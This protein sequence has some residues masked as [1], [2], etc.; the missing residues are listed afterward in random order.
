MKNMR[1]VARSAAVIAGVVIAVTGVTYAALQSPPNKLTGNTIQTATA[2]LLVSTDGTNYAMSHPGF[3]FTGL[4]PGGSAVP[5]SGYTVWVRS[6]GSAT[7]GLKLSVP[8]TPS[9][10]DGVDLSKVSIVLTPI[11][12]GTPQTFSLQSLMSSGGVDV[13]LPNGIFPGNTSIFTLKAS[14]SADAISGNGAT[15]GNIDFAFIGVAQSN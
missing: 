15:L 12:G 4:V 9:N 2:N 5:A 8:S 7:L 3:N 6:T 10:P 14:M 1:M 13:T 11:N